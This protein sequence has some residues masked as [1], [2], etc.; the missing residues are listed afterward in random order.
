MSL[1]RTLLAG[2]MALSAGAANAADTLMSGSQPG[3]PG[4][5]WG[6][7]YLG[8]YAGRTFTTLGTFDRVG[9]QAGYNLVRGQFLVGVEGHGAVIITPSGP[10]AAEVELSARLGVILRSRL[11]IYGEAG[12]GMLADQGVYA[13]GGGGEIAV[14]DSFSVFAE[15]KT[16]G[17]FLSGC[18]STTVQFGVNYHP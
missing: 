8:V 15:A 13:F 1:K 11:L 18:C 2:V 4:F 3:T 14:R 5:S 16:F 10:A 12:I 6:G 17:T 7:A 9:G